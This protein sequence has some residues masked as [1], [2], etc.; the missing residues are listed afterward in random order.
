MVD[1]RHLRREQNREAVLD[2]LA[3]LFA[4]GDYQPG[5]NEIARR[6]GISPRSLFRYFDDVDDLHRAAIER[7]L[8]AARPLLE[9][10]VDPSAPTAEKVERVVDA[11]MR[12]YGTVGGAGR[13]ARIA[14]HRSP[15]VAA[16]LRDARAYLRGQLATL[17]AVE[18]SRPG[19]TGLLPAL[20]A[21]CS[22]ETHEL[23]RFDQK[24][25]RP[26]TRAALV[27]ALTTLV[28]PPEAR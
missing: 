12:L 3:T 16:Q 11:R 15:V 25:S 23:L 22:F 21:L 14:A 2:T 26:A 8:A 17:F 20:D 24:L 4:E 7:Q 27:A 1:G 19:R 6:A 28:A 18:L 10:P 9:L 5:T 13:A